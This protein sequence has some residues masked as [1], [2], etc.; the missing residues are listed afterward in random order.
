MHRVTE[1]GLV[2]LAPVLPTVLFSGLKAVAGLDQGWDGAPIK[3]PLGDVVGRGV[4]P[5]TLQSHGILLEH[6]DPWGLEVQHSLR[7][8]C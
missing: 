3:E 4:G 7:E 6:I 1:A 2:H 5:P 8:I